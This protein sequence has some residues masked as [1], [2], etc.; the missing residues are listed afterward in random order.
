MS[1]LDGIRKYTIGAAAL[2][3]VAVPVFFVAMPWLV[4]V[5][6]G[7]EYVGAVDAARIVLFAAAI[8]FA[9]GWTKSLP[10]TI[11]RPRLRIVTHGVETLV[12]VPARRRPRGRVGRDGGG[13]R[14][15]RLDARLRGCMGDRPRAAAGRGRRRSHAPRAGGGAVKAVVVSGIWPPDPG[16]PA[17]H[18]PAL[19]A[20]LHGRGHGVEV[21]TTADEAPE[22][23]A[24]PVHWIPRSSPLRHARTALLVRSRA[25][26]SD[27]VYAT[28][29]IRRAA[30]GAS[31]ARRPLVV[32][33][34]SDEVFERARRSGR[35]QGTL[36]EF[37]RV[38]GSRARFLRATRDA[39]LRRARHV[40]C[41]SAYLRE[42]RARLGSGRRPRHG[43]AEPGAGDTAAPLA[44]GAAGGARAATATCS[45]SP[46]GSAR[47]S[48]STSPSRRSPRRR[49]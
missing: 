45:P 46:A 11:G 33:L 8:Q 14:G 9:I 21:V 10:V 25:S 41:P 31:L 27:V 12:A 39:A 7:T 40:F 26:R 3:V 42:D 30:L 19:A 34:V 2:M 13:D 29:M 43:A 4:E 36:D 47:R 6:F 16:G 37:Q 49:A 23:R 22:S 1:V 20:F 32:K 48:R 15:P 28:S 5:I 35:Y 24:Y 17:S 38:G 18:A 44:R